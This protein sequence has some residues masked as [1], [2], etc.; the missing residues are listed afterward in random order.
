MRR[1]SEDHWPGENSSTVPD[2]LRE[3]RTSTD[4]SPSAISTHS[5]AL[6]LNLLLRQTGVECR[7]CR[8]GIQNPSVRRA[9]LLLA[10]ARDEGVDLGRS[11]QGQRRPLLVDIPR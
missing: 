11:Q 10:A 5:P 7:L 1:M 6:P 9:A 2:G 8:L 4:C 3:S